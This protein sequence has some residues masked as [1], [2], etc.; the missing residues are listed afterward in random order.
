MRG[1]EVVTLQFSNPPVVFSVGAAGSCA[2]KEIL[3]G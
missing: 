2:S 3:K 1:G